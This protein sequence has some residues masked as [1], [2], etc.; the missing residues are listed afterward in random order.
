MGKYDALREEALGKLMAA[1]RIADSGDQSAEADATFQRLLA[2]FRTLDG[3]ARAINPA[4]QPGSWSLDG[5]NVSA[6]GIGVSRNGGAI[7]F[8]GGFGGGMGLPGRPS[9]HRES[10]GA[11]VV[12]ALS[13][14]SR[15]F[16]GV[17]GSESVPV[18]VPLNVTP[19]QEGQR[20]QFLRQLIPTEDAPVGR[21]SYMRQTVRTNNAAAVA[22]AARKPT[23]IYTLVRI[24]DRTRTIAHL[25]EPIPRQE[26]ADAA[27]LRSFVDD[28]LRY[29]LD[30]ELD[31]EILS[32]DGVEEME[33]ILT[34][35]GTRVQ[36][37]VVDRLTTCRKAITR[38]E[39]SELPATAFAMNPQDWEAIELE[40]LDQFASNAAVANP[41]EPLRRAL[42]G[43]PVLVT[44]AIAEGTAVC[45][46]FRGSSV[47]YVTQEAQVDW[48]ENV[49]DP[50]F[51]G[52]GASDFERNVLRF[53]AEM[54]A[55][56]AVTRPVGFV[57]VDLAVGS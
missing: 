12:D 5:L 40:A 9:I 41:I 16:A 4:H 11:K 49:F 47:L 18:S 51:G 55:A 54:R 6:G 33:G 43:L 52:T 32:G 29:G 35:P 56:I 46:D 21:F 44:N 39:V 24:D 50:A 53:R 2:E 42:F 30:V 38:L 8:P 7:P 45:G 28:E 25:T 19:V 3:Q 13:G 57:E 31:R 34:A 1:R 20:A 10:W 22:E 15:P 14:P 37:F 27:M 36:P 48:S 17:V 26:V 23:S